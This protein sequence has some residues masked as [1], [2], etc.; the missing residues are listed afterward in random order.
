[1]HVYESRQ[2]FIETI[3][4]KPYMK[5]HI[6]VSQSSQNIQNMFACINPSQVTDT[7]LTKLYMKKFAIVPK[8][9]IVRI[10]KD[11]WFKVQ[12]FLSASA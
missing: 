5:M 6:I 7:S 8:L 12:N 1:M 10:A 11:V 3:L 9:V 4:A 2:A